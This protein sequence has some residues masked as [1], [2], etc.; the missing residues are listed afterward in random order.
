MAEAELT[1]PA[2][3]DVHPSLAVPH[4]VVF[5]DSGLSE[6]RREIY[7]RFNND[8]WRPMP[9]SLSQQILD[10]W[11]EGCVRVSFNWDWSNTRAKSFQSC[12]EETLINRYTIDFDIMEQRDLENNQTRKVKVVGV[13]RS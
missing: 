1:E 6:S 8:M 5:W 12:A 4:H 11:D 10:K 7:V 9:D 3:A 2:T 13:V